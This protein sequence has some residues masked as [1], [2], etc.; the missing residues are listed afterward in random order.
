MK[1][2][3]MV[4]PSTAFFGSSVGNFFVK[5]FN[6]GEAYLLL[7][8]VL[9]F[10]MTYGL[11]YVVMCKI[12]PHYKETMSPPLEK[13]EVINNN[14]QVSDIPHVNTHESNKTTTL[15]ETEG[16]DTEDDS[17]QELGICKS[18]QEECWS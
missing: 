5:S 10:T 17:D 4:L 12:S 14:V 18:R 16:K 13:A 15:E 2:Y 11:G 8:L 9:A 6:T 3:A 7:L 1:P